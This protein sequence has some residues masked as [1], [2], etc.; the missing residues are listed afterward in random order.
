M[1]CMPLCLIP[2][3]VIH[4]F[5][6]VQEEHEQLQEFESV[7]AS[8]EKHLE[9]WEGRL[10]SV[11]VPPQMYISKVGQHKTDLVLKSDLCIEY[12]I[13]RD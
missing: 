12:C 8:L 10:K 9:D 2:D 1:L 6:C 5:I 11:T 7:L 4:A 3:H 13:S